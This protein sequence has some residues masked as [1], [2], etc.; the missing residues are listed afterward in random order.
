LSYFRYYYKSPLICLTYANIYACEIRGYLL[1]PSNLNMGHSYLY[2]HFSSIYIVLS[3]M[4]V[5]LREWR[6]LRRANASEFKML[7]NI[8]LVLQFAPNNYCIVTATSSFLLRR[9]QMLQ[10]LRWWGMSCL[11]C[12]LH[13]IIIVLLNLVVVLIFECLLS[14][15]R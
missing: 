4:N 6:C 14:L 7:R 12:S 3:I 11:C 5:F 15:V 9:T 8:M 2:L 13:P 10:N 1:C